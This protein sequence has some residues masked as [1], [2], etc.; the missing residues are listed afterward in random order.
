RGFVGFSAYM[1]LAELLN[2]ILQQVHVLI[3][4]RYAG[5]EATAIYG[6]AELITRIVANM[7][8]AFDSIVA[9]M[10]AESLHLGERDRMQHNLRLVTRWV[11]TA[12]VPLAAIVISLR[13]ELLVGIFNKPA[14][15]A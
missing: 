3:V 14:Y 7:R 5:L 4:T 12:A 11:T 8:Y 10:M 6:A 9:G 1:G 15:A 13:T 2:A